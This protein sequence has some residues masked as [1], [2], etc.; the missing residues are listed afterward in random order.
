[1]RIIALIDD[2]GLIRRILEQLG[3]R[4]PEASGPG[5]P[6]PG[7]PVNAVIP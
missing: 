7:W 2:P 1:M 6:A 5:P 3:L 4:A